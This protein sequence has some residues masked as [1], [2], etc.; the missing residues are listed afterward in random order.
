MQAVQ[1]YS[2]DLGL[3]QVGMWGLVGTFIRDS[4]LNII[5]YSQIANVETVRQV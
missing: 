2:I 1:K 4:M 5:Y 3:M